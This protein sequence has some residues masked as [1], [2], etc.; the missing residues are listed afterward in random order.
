MSGFGPALGNDEIVSIL[1]YVRS[2]WTDAPAD[3]TNAFVRKI[4][5]AEKEKTGPYEAN[6]LWKN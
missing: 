5:A 3:V 4:R 2:T 6:A 1:S